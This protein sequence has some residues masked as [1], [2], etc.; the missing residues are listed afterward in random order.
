M[1]IRND[2]MERKASTDRIYGTKEL[3]KCLQAVKAAAQLPVFELGA[4]QSDLDLLSIPS[5]KELASAL[6]TAPLLSESIL[7]KSL[8]WSF[9]PWYSS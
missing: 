1:A 7:L 4:F 3:V 6:V 2:M 9:S 8:L 5:M